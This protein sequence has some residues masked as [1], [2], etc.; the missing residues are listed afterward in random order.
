MN[1]HLP[2]SNRSHRNG[3]VMNLPSRIRSVGF[4]RTVIIGC[5]LVGCSSS[6]HETSTASSSPSAVITET[7]PASGST[8]PAAPATDAVDPCRLLTDAEAG[9]ALGGPAHH[10]E[11]DPSDASNGNG[12]TVT[13][14]R[15]EYN[16]I[17]SDQLG[18]DIWVGV[19]DGADRE[20]YDETGSANES[21]QI[22]GIGDAA[23]GNASVVYAVRGGTMI[24]M[25]GSVVNTSTLAD[26]PRLAVAHLA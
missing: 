14:R 26:L 25:Y 2:N 9:A 19:Y 17:T 24:E 8:Q 3:P 13:E 10:V 4:S 6:P 21:T 20:Y 1:D 16:L 22:S 5:V 7:A 12:I 15:C 11:R 23:K 18:H